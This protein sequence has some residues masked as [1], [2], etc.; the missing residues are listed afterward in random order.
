MGKRLVAIP[1]DECIAGAQTRWRIDLTT[2]TDAEVQLLGFTSPIKRG[3]STCIG[4][5]EHAILYL[6]PFGVNLDAA[7][8]HRGE[9]VGVRASLI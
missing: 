5:Q 4:M 8:R 3:V 2:I 7:N 9:R 6:A 1:A